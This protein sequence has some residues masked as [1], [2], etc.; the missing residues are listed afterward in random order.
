MFVRDNRLFLFGSVFKNSLST[1]NA[2]MYGIWQEMTVNDK[3]EEYEKKCLSRL[4]WH[5]P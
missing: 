4:L 3:L 1:A 2:V 5:F